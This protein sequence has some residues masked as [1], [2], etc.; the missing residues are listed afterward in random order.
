MAQYQNVSIQLVD[1]PPVWSE[2]CESFVFDNIRACDGALAL[3]DLGAD[4]PA[5]GFVQTL[6]LLREKHI[7]LTAPIPAREENQTGAV[8]IESCLVLNKADLDPSGELAALVREV[9]DTPL[10]WRV[11][12]AKERLGLDELRQAM[13]D[14]L[15][16]IRIYPKEPG[17][18]PDLLAPFTMASGSTIL[19]FAI[20][21]HRDF[22]DRLKSARV[23]GSAKFDGQEVHRNHVL[24]DGDVV[25]LLL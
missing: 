20:R 10:P 23:W 15:H 9:I 7:E 21:V 8:Q 18:P 13:F 11:I 2:H 5:E 19:D 1:L 17:K 16:V 22:A 4:D 12:S 14:L 3:V 6:E 25:E 24:K